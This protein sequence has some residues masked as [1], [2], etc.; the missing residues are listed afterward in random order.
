MKLF[1][2]ILAAF[3]E[4]GK[5]KTLQILRDMPERQLRDA[6]ISPELLSQGVK[7]WPW[8]DVE[9]EAVAPIL[10]DSIAVSKV[11]PAAKD[12]TN[13]AALETAEE[14]TREEAVLEQSAA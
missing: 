11:A 4:S 5:K 8:T 13:E 9:E 7:A 10:I 6:G 3:E 14:A 1:K 12:L 2:S